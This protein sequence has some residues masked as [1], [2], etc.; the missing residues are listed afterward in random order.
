M[1]GGSVQD[2]GPYGGVHGSGTVECIGVLLFNHDTDRVLG[3][4]EK[5][6]NQENRG[7]AVVEFDDDE[8][9]ETI[10]KKVAGEP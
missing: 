10:R 3:K 8:A 6:W 4:V 7:M 9:A 5:A 1:A 2:P